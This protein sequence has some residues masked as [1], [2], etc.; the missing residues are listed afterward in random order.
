[1]IYGDNKTPKKILSGG[2]TTTTHKDPLKAQ[3]VI[4]GDQFARGTTF[5]ASSHPGWVMKK[6]Y[7]GSIAVIN[8]KS[9]DGWFSRRNYAAI[10]FTGVRVVNIE[11][12]V[13]EVA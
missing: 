5:V 4:R 3:E 13:S 12:T 6:M 1:M 10:K 11:M 2:V 9:G 8:H 7:D